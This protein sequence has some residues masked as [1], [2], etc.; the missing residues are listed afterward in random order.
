MPVPGFFC[1]TIMDKK[2][3][4]VTLWLTEPTKIGLM[5]LA[6]AD[7]RA[8]GEYVGHVL[9]CHVYG[10]LAQLEHGCEADAGGDSPA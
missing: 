5:H 7:D 8:L 4:R 9:S 1:L 10:H 3:E 2:T 6:A